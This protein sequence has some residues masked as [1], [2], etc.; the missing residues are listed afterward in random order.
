[1]GPILAE[2]GMRKVLHSHGLCGSGLAREEAMSV[3]MDIES[4]YAFASRLAPTGVGS[5]QQNH[6]VATALTH[7]GIT[8]KAFGQWRLEQTLG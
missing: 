3:D 1:M 2:R 4:H 8:L 5:G 6:L 7:L